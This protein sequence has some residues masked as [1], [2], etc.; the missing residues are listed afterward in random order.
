[1]SGLEA[2]IHQGRY[3]SKNDLLNLRENAISK[4][5]P[6][7][8]DAVNQRLKKIHPT[9]YQRLVGPLRN[10]KRDPKFQCYCNNP[11]SLDGICQE[12]IAGTV[13]PHCL[14]CDACWQEDITVVWGYY[15]WST[16]QI[17]KS[18]WDL[19]CQERAVYK[20]VE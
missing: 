11:K 4:E 15:G 8:V 2:R 1:M 10:R 20:F 13:H 7:I 5:R 9:V 16:K 3:D 17:S 12:I 6:D 19:L 14:T 18:T